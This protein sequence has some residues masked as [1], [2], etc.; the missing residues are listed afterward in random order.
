MEDLESAYQWGCYGTEI[1]G[2]DGLVI[3]A[4]L[5]NTL[6][7][8]A[9]CS[10]TNTAAY[11]SLN[12]TIENYSDWYLPSRDELVEILERIGQDSS[13]GNIGGFANIKY[14]SSSE[15]GSTTSW[16]VNFDSG[17]MSNQTKSDAFRARI[18]RSF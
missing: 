5:Q 8:V 3:G 9:G 17:T 7:I 2:A 13:I 15:I 16:I 1:S 11:Q 12:L 4:G 6:D 18:I 10:A 14:W